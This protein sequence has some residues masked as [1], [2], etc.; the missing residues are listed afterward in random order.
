MTKKFCLLRESLI[1][2]IR[3]MPGAMEM[4]ESKFEL[5]IKRRRMWRLCSVRLR[6]LLLQPTTT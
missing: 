3:T 6:S 4:T 2:S 5:M 1:T